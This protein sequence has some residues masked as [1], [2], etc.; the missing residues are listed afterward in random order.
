MG[1][2]GHVE[3]LRVR[4]SA[5]PIRHLAGW[6]PRRQPAWGPPDAAPLRRARVPVVLALFGASALYVSYGHLAAGLVRQWASDDNYSHGFAVVP[7]AAYAAWQ[8]RHELRAARPCPTAWGL[9]LVGAGA[10]IYAIGVAGAELFLARVSFLLVLAGTVWF[11]LGSEH[12]RLLRF[13]LLLLLLAI[14][15]PTVVFNQL[16]LPL[17]LFAATIGETLL[18]GA[19]IP[20]LR[21]GNVLELVGMRLEVAEACSGIRS[22]VSLLTVAL[23]IGHLGGA[24]RARRLAL[25]AATV[26]VAILANAV[27]VA[28]TGAAAHI[29]G[30]AAAEG[31]LHTAAGALTFGAA[32]AALLLL[33]RVMRPKLEAL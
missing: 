7:F 2:P 25:A 33:D 19:G 27:R 28:A 21:D 5:R 29:W 1:Q 31:V 32:A 12:L 20:V 3:L 15:L 23:V 26:P 30:P 14:P 17:Q 16:A 24:T 10:L 18:R 8:R 6:L 22:L 9:A 4:G 11:V 13:P